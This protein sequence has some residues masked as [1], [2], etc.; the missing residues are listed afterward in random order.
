[1][2]LLM[3]VDPQRRFADIQDP[4]GNPDE[5]RSF[6]LGKDPTDECTHR[7]WDAIQ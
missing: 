6:I 2:H 1:M 4:R 7:A 3:D 5:E